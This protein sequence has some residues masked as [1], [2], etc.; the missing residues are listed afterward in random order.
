MTSFLAS[1]MNSDS[2]LN[3]SVSVAEEKQ[4][5]PQVG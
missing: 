4:L 2:D 3:K 5:V 1:G